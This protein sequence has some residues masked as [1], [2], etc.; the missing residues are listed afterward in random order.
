M[1]KPAYNKSFNRTRDSVAARFRGNVS[2]APVNSD[3][4]CL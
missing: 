2:T 3:V 1:S 4:M